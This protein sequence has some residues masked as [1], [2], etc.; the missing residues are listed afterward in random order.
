MSGGTLAEPKTSDGTP[1]WKK[2]VELNDQLNTTT[3]EIAKDLPK[4]AITYLIV[5]TR[6]GFGWTTQKYKT[7]DKLSITSKNMI[8]IKED[9]LGSQAVMCAEVKLDGSKGYIPIRNIKK[10]TNLQGRVKLG[11]SAQEMAMQMIED[12]CNSNNPPLIINSKSVVKQAS[13]K[14]DIVVMLSN[15]NKFQVEV[16]G[17][18]DFSKE[19]YF[20]DKS[21]SRV[22][23]EKSQEIDKYVRAMMLNNNPAY[24]EMTTGRDEDNWINKDHPLTLTRVIDYQ[25]VV[26]GDFSVGYAQDEGVTLKSGKMPKFLSTTDN[27]ACSEIRDLIINKFRSGNDKDDYF[28]HVNTSTKEV[29]LYIIPG[30]ADPL[31]LSKLNGTNE[32]R[33]KFKSFPEFSRAQLTPPGTASG[34][35][36]RV[37]VKATLKY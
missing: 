7:G 6:D 20:Y 17:T 8:S 37:G 13:N 25:R 36:T 12:I 15:G 14:P 4:S 5:K 22:Q 23:D 27:T 3:Y 31:R 33:G 34:S 11:A 18:L 26:K 16:K 32:Y 28:A 35:G 30:T 24:K 21:V 10:P 1:A 2:Y 9:W 29:R 19:V